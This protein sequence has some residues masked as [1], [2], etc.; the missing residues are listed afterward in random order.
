MAYGII[1]PVEKTTVYVDA[2]HQRRLRALARHTG[3][4]QA[5]LIREALGLYLD[6]REEHRL[7]SWVGIVRDGPGTDASTIK[8]DVRHALASPADGGR[9]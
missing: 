4:P 3:R 6:A 1:A 5:E 2:E 8:D 9:S 7:P